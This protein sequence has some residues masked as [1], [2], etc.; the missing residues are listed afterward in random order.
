MS[1]LDWKRGRFSMDMET[2]E[3]EGALRGRQD[4]AGDQIMYF[5]F[6][7]EDSEMDNLYDEG[8]GAGRVF[9][10]PIPVP[11]LHATHEEGPAEQRNEGFYFSD[12]IHV[13]A[14]YEML[15]RVGFSNQD[16]NTG[17]YLKDRIVYDGKVF[18]VL[19]VEV[20]GQ[21]QRRDTIVAI[22]A[23]QMKPDE[24]TGDPQFAAYATTMA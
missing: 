2:N 18:R 20:L 7:A 3:I 16:I 23:T 6:S 5:R 10:G 15:R 21:I 22:D 4:L 17:S 1:R 8:S 11:V 19:K 12:N 13:T 9:N 14:G 24:F